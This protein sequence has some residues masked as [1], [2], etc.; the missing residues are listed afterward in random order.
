MGFGVGDPS[1]GRPLP[2]DSII[3]TIILIMILTI[4]LI[5]LKI[6]DFLNVTCHHHDAHLSPPLSVKSIGSGEI[7]II[8]FILKMI[9]CPPTQCEEQRRWQI[10]EA[11]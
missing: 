1:V 9:T 7:L 11:G 10:G 3:L 4:I 5:I 8:I 2:L 6:H